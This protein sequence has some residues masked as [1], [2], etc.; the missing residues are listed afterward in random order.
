MRIGGPPRPNEPRTRLQVE[1]IVP[2]YAHRPK[3]PKTS[4]WVLGWNK[5]AQLLVVVVVVVV[6][7]AL[8]VPKA[9]AAAAAAAAATARVP[10][11]IPPITDL[12]APSAPAPPP[13]PAVPP[14]PPVVLVAPPCDDAPAWPPANSSASE[15][16][17]IRIFIAGYLSAKSTE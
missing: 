2:G 16:A 11:L 9:N 14:V 5:N 13:A 12:L 1:R 6:V 10:L 3:K 8:L 4:A 17:R 15:T 7:L